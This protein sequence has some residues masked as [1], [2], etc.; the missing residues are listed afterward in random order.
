MP[1]LL[2]IGHFLI[3]LS[4]FV[5]WLFPIYLSIWPSIVNPFIYHV[6]PALYIM[7]HWRKVKR[8][9]LHIHSKRYFHVSILLFVLAVFWAIC[10]ILYNN[11][12]DYSYFTKLFIVFRTIYV[13]VFLLL[14]AAE[15]I[16]NGSML[17]RFSYFWGAA[18]SVCVFFT[19]I[20]LV[21]PDIRSFWQEL[22]VSND[23]K[24]R[25]L[26]EAFYITRFGIGGF[27]GFE[28]SIIA[29]VSVILSFYLIERRKPIGMLFL[30]C[31]LLGNLFYGRIGVILSVTA[32]VFLGI[33]TLTLRKV[34]KYAAVGACVF[35]II[36]SILLL[37]DDPLL[38]I[39]KEWLLLPIDSFFTGLSMGQL[40]F[41][42]SA[43]RLVYDMYFWP[44]D[45]T[46]LFGDGRY[47][48]LNGSYYMQTDA[49]LM[50]IILYFGAIGAMFV[51]VSYLFLVLGVVSNL[52]NEKFVL[53]VCKL[54]PVLFFISEYKGDP[55]PL[56][57]GF[58]VVLLLCSN[59]VEQVFNQN[60]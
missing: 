17:E 41:G 34:T 56:F 13:D 12:S 38:D 53:S 35:G 6:V 42:P 59:D 46:F 15:I 47:T 45:D 7:L 50:R 36:S 30:L 1:S 5:Y 37:W 22:L 51:Y 31:S 44:G 9:F 29:S 25:A 48:N 57:F 54:S 28:E 27:A 24:E 43:D 49:G 2:H 23:S 10:S 16:R 14:L 4:A 40:S 33:S 18:V 52:E 55:Y 3:V 11:T 60:P 8:L 26:L 21:F 39:W 58:A 32:I 19:M 20:T